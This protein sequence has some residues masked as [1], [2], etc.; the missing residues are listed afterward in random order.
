MT[1]YQFT[2]LYCNHRWKSDF[3]PDDFIMCSKCK[4]ENIQVK[5]IKKKDYYV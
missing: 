1:E 5:K 2:C 4:D 3:P